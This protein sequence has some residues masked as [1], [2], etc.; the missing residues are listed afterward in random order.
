MAR[1]VSSHAAS[2]PVLLTVLHSFDPAARAIAGRTAAL[3]R[4][5]IPTACGDALCML[6]I[7]DGIRDLCPDGLHVG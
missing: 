1:I 3:R 7:F 6:R 5:V 2:S 4:D